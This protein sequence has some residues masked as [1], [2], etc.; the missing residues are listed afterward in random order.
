MPT[1]TD[2]SPTTVV[3]EAMTRWLR[4]CRESIGA[5][6]SEEWINSN[7]QD[8]VAEYFSALNSAPGEDAEERVA[9]AYE[10][11]RVWAAARS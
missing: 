1:I 4:T 6:A 2:I 11:I 10:T 8:C 3:A 9:A 7:L 5:P